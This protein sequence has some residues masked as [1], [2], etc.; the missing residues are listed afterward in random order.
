MKA[1]WKQFKQRIRAHKL[2]TASWNSDQ[3]YLLEIAQQ[4]EAW[5]LDPSN[6]CRAGISNLRNIVHTARKAVDMHDRKHLAQLFDQAAYMTMPQLRAAIGQTQIEQIPFHRTSAPVQAFH[7]TLT[8][9]QL[10]RMQR[11]FQH[12]Y[13]F[14]PEA[15]VERTVPGIGN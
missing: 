7:V 9:D 11:S 12:R 10:R 13:E 2:A 14:I 8:P 1:T 15:Y 5:K 6:A 4:A 3:K